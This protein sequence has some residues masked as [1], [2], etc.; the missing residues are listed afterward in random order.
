[1]MTAN[2]AKGERRDEGQAIA[3]IGRTECFIPNLHVVLFSISSHPSDGPNPLLPLPV[4]CQMNQEC[5][6]SFFTSI[7]PSYHSNVPSS[8][9]TFLLSTIFIV[10]LLYQHTE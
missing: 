3:E 8:L 2:M 1:M 4:Y 10:Y 7:Y 6:L 5:T 9:I